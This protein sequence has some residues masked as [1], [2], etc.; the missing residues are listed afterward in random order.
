[1]QRKQKHALVCSS[2]LLSLSSFADS[3]PETQRSINLR[4]LSSSSQS[5]SVIRTSL[6]DVKEKQPTVSYVEKRVLIAETQFKVQSCGVNNSRGKSSFSSC[7]TLGI[8]ETRA[9]A[10]ALLPSAGN[11]NTTIVEVVK[12]VP[13]IVSVPQI[14]WEVVIPTNLQVLR[15]LEAN[16]EFASDLNSAASKLC[17][18]PKLGAKAVTRDQDNSSST[19][20]VFIQNTLREEL[21]RGKYV[22]MVDTECR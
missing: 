17:N 9:E 10:E 3:I 11:S 13:Q 16:P 19:L 2:L 21:Y 7:T 5:S 18:I 20:L 14:K 8:F 22:L 4:L 12:R 1:M 15:D 6:L